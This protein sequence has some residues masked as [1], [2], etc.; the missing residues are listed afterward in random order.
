MPAYKENNGTWTAKFK[1]KDRLGQRQQKTK[2]GFARKKDAQDYEV[3]FKAKYVHS[4]NIPLHALVSNYLDDLGQN[5]KIAITTVERKTK[6]FETKIIPVL[7]KKPINQIDSL[8]I[9]NWQNWVQKKG[10][11]KKP[12]TGYAPTYLKS[13][14][15]EMSAV[16]NYAVRYYKLTQNPCQIAGSMGKSEADAMQIWTLD[17]YE[18]F[19]K[20]ADKTDAKVA[21]DILFWAGI[22]EGELLALTPDDFLPDS[23]LNISK[24]FAVAEGE[25]II[26]DPKN[27]SSNRCIAIPEFLHAEVE[28]YIHGLYGIEA[29]DRLFLFT[30]SFLLNEIKRT[31][32]KADLDP[33]RVHDLRHSHA[34]LLIEMGFNILAISERLGHK[35][36]QTTW[37]TYAHLYPDKGRQIAFG[38]QEAKVTGITANHTAEDQMLSLL[39]SIQKMLPNYSTYETDDIILWDAVEKKKE[40]ITRQKFNAMLAK[41][42]CEDPE[43]MDPEEAFVVMM[44][45]GYYELDPR[46]IFCFSSRGMPIQYL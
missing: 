31:A 6:A 12:D 2:R 21:F 16:M 45:D 43:S 37:N 35:K 9:L 23:K 36:V 33:I 29:T 3:D 25:Q 34:S 8:D 40:I 11:E 15:N 1:Y 24:S 38:L 30:K 4:A 28:N 39:T 5:Q 17:Q 27:E 41:R 44:Q 10:F 20:A 26:K 42:K 18:Q 14:N 7:G 32:K 22:R 46:F 19:I 13:I